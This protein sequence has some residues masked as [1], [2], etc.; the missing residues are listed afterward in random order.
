MV[1]NKILKAWADCMQKLCILNVLLCE[2][3]QLRSKRSLD[4]NKLQTEKLHVISD[5]KI[6]YLSSLKTTSRISVWATVNSHSH[7]I[8]IVC[9]KKCITRLCLHESFLCFK[10]W[11]LDAACSVASLRAVALAC[12][13][14]HVTLW[15]CCLCFWIL[16]YN[17]TGTA[18]KLRKML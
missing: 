6:Y 15:T 10:S 3:K 16:W 7:M 17:W 9:E 13:I 18:D 1:S 14:A 5:H 11:W 4:M 2:M 8:C 12:S